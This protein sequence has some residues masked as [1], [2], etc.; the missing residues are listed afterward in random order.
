MGAVGLS[1][2]EKLGHRAPAANELAD[3]DAVGMLL[4]LDKIPARGE[5][6][7]G[8]LSPGDYATVPTGGLPPPSIGGLT[9]KLDGQS[10]RQ[11]GKH[12]QSEESAVL[13]VVAA[14]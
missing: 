13:D 14:L 5:G 11:P 1:H 9:R 6:G 12:T 2:S 4:E 10:K 3:Q 8:G 7:Y